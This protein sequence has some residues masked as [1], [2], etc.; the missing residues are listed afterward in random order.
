MRW[1]KRIGLSRYDFDGIDLDAA[2]AVLRDGELP[3]DQR[4]SVAH[5]K[6]GFG[7]EPML[8]SETLDLGPGPVM[9]PLV[10]AAAP[11]LNGL[12]HLAHRVAGRGG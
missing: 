10:R 1:A 7:G 2:L 9:R 8:L 12:R 3:E 5:F 4:H 11:R 6:L